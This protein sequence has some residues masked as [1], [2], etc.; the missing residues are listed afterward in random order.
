[1]PLVTVPVID[2][3]PYRSGSEASRRAVVQQVGDACREI[4][5]LIIAGH[6]VS[7]VLDG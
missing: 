3:A 2:I 4:G 1:M 7:Q 5:F 6:G